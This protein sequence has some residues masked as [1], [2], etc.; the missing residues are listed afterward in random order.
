MSDVEPEKKLYYSIGDVTKITGVEQHVLRYW[1]SEFRELRPRKNSSGKRLYRERDIEV[2]LAIKKLL[3][4]DRYTT[5]GAQKRLSEMTS[6]SGLPSAGELNTILQNLKAGL[7]DI[8][9]IMD[10]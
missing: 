8:R 4:E 1:E 6:G 7:E 5:E 3:Y 9:R 10:S 2:L